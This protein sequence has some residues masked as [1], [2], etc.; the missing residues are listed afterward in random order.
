M[1]GLE[2]V[3][4]GDARGILLGLN[5]L[6]AEPDQ[7][8]FTDAPEGAV[9]AVAI[10]PRAGGDPVDCTQGCT[11]LEGDTATLSVSVGSLPDVSGRDVESAT[12]ELADVN[13]S[14]AGT[15]EEFSDDFD[16]GEVIY[17]ADREGGGS[18]RPGDSVTLVV[19]AGPPLFAVPNIVGLTRD[20]AKAALTEA[21][22]DYEYATLWD[23]V[24]DEITEV[25]SQ[26]P[27]AGTEH[28]RGTV[29]SFRIN[30]AF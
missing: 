27:A 15:A 14:V 7:E 18:W 24:L 23:A 20:Q 9:I 21:G 16:A 13:L 5:L 19:S 1:Q 29:V 11:A 28:P 8:F 6:V 25:E 2:G 4:A 17:V 12:E 3:S 22:F 10:T 30:G 26:V